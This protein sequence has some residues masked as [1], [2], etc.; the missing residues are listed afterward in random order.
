MFQGQVETD[1]PGAFKRKIVKRVPNKKE[2]LVSEDAKLEEVPGVGTVFIRTQGC[3][4][5]ISD[6]EYMTGLLVE[7][8]YTVVDTVEEADCCLLN[9]CTVKNPSQDTFVN[10]IKKAKDLKKPIVVSGCVP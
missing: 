1:A 5:N 6:S 7:Y 9:S 2:K 3:S 4:H 8:G 10:M